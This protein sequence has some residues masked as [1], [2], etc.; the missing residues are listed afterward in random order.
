M[1]LA[2]PLGLGIRVAFVRFA[3]NLTS[4]IYAR[5]Y[6]FRFFENRK[7]FKRVSLREPRV[8]YPIDG[9]CKNLHIE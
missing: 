9:E 1:L 7:E 4:N 8:A 2:L 6:K 5:K 3:H